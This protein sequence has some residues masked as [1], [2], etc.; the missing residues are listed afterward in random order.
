MGDADEDSIVDEFSETI[1]EAPTEHAVLIV[2]LRS[3]H[4]RWPLW[5]NPFE[6]NKWYCGKNRGATGPYC[7]AHGA[8]ARQPVIRAKR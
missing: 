3:C 2:D 1:P 7:P 4:C 5:Q 6:Q 8:Q